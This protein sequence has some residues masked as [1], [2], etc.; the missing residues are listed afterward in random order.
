MDQ[1]KP[2]NTEEEFNTAIMFATQT[3]NKWSRYKGY[4]PELLVFGKMSKCPGSVINEGNSASHDLALQESPEGVQFRERLA[5]RERARKAFS[6]VDNAQSLRRAMQQ[7]SRPQRSAYL[8]GDWI[9]ARRKEN[10]WFGPLKVVLQED[11]NVIWA[12]QGNK[13][14]R[15]ASEHARSLSAVE[16]IQNMNQIR[17]VDTPQTLDQ[18]RSGN[19]RYIPIQ[20][21]EIPA[22]HGPRRNNDESEESLEQPDTEPDASEKTNPSQPGSDVDYSPTSPTPPEPSIDAP[23]N[24]PVPVEEE[25]DLVCDAYTLNEDQVWRFEVNLDTRDIDTLRND[26][27]P[28][29][30]AFLVSAA[31]RQRSE[32]K[33]ATLTSAERQLFD[34]AKAKEVQSWLDTQ[35][36]CRIQRHKIPMQNILLTWNAENNTHLS[37]DS[38]QVSGR[39]AKARLVILGYQDPELSS[40]ERDSPTLSKLSRDLLLQAC[41]SNRWE[42]G[43]FDIKTAFL[44]GRADSRMLGVGTT[45]R[46]ESQ[47]EPANC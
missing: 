8:P 28:T 42:I 31:K 45:T 10:Q 13:L 23:E 30:F 4:P 40:L 27:N 15:L 20:P 7:R 44:R 37:A 6:E 36:V 38:K 29:A 39:K 17:H 18:I 35:A 12:V 5:L 24:I 14:F 26:P 2:I 25:D 3:K 41:V 21:S 22:P 43:S 47:D 11:K 9:M 33:L 32:V 1:E 34:A 19:T 16:E 46:P